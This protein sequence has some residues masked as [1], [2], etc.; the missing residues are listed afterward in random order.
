MNRPVRPTD[1]FDR[2]AGD[3]ISESACCL[4]SSS[5]RDR[6]TRQRREAR[7]DST[8]LGRTH[9]DTPWISRFLIRKVERSSV[10][11]DEPVVG[12]KDIQQQMQ[13]KKNTQQRDASSSAQVSI[14]L[15]QN[16][17]LSSE[18]DRPRGCNISD[19]GSHGYV[20]NGRDDEDEFF[21]ENEVLDDERRHRRR[22][23]KQRPFVRQRRFKI[24]RGLGVYFWIAGVIN[25]VGY[26]IM[27]AA[28]KA[29]SEDAVG[30]V[31]LANILPAM[32]VKASAPYW[33]EKVPYDT[34][35]LV[36]TTLMVASFVTVAAS[37][38]GSDSSHPRSSALFWQLTGVACASAQGGLGEA[39]LLA[40]AGKIDGESAA[41]DD[42][43]LAAGSDG[44]SS[45]RP[46]EKATTSGK[47]TCLNG[48]S[49]GT[50]FAGVFGFFWKWFFNNW[51][52]LSLSVTLWL[53]T[54]LAVGYLA[55]FH[56]VKHLRQQQEQ[57][58]ET[59][60]SRT[61]RREE[62][63]D[64]SGG[65][66]DR[67]RYRDDSSGSV[68]DSR[69][70]LVSHRSEAS[71]YGAEE[72][73]D[74]DDGGDGKEDRGLVSNALS[75]YENSADSVSPISS[76]GVQEI[77][78]MSGPERF[79]LVLSLWPYMVPLFTV[80]VAEYTLQSGTWSAIGFPVTSKESRDEFYQYSNWT[81][82]V[83]VFI[84]RSSGTFVV[85]PM[86]LLW[87]MP[88]LQCANVWI[89]W[90]VAANQTADATTTATT[91]FWSSPWF[92]YPTALYT[93]FLGGA[94]YVHGY[95]RIC[96][97]LPLEHR[98]FALSAT[99]LAECLGIVVADF[100]G[101]L[102]QACLY[103]INGLEAAVACPRGH[104]DRRY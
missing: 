103:E 43:L 55:S 92:L 56:A 26:V 6:K 24:R 47:G 54:I 49:S 28:A 104:H 81:Y 22:R 12:R 95:L 84:S 32:V 4:G 57:I 100:L 23:P 19:D 83:G 40:L 8:R 5:H 15:P 11:R 65:G 97:D 94:V 13:L 2:W 42:A 85:A 39:S 18:S 31:F 87:A 69:T 102:V 89:Y 37:S 78:S 30:L 93:G 75:P 71:R 68:Q 80:Y 41:L 58:L 48:F 17:P 35:L 79:R 61:R 53:A 10:G 64:R 16:L 70:D 101:L 9:A 3:R 45:H 66:R 36:A 63:E 51:L 44:P 62:E 1:P 33:F 72:E 14:E 73:D 34:R 86:S 7:L 21:D 74:D 52:G 91:S 76:P 50:G 27:I 59:V 29:I 46:G 77:S 88:F 38:S 60:V 82:Q 99:S 25:N 96:R 98:E 20:D 67:S 90:A